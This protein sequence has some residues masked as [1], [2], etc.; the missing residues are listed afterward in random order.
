LAR[1][2]LSWARSADGGAQY[3]NQTIYGPFREAQPFSISGFSNGIT[4]R[5]SRGCP[6]S[7]PVARSVAFNCSQGLSQ[8]EN[9]PGIRNQ[10]TERYL[11]AE[12]DFVSAVIRQPGTGKVGMASRVSESCFRPQAAFSFR[13]AA[14]LR[15]CF[16][17]RLE[18]LQLGPRLPYRRTDR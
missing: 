1:P 4:P 7:E 10:T 14:R 9:V 15:R 13:E 17:H 11:E 18:N 6:E 12:Q 5:V 3:H 16:K 2:R 8:D